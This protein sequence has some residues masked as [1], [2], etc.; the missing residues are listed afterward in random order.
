M[1]GTKYDRFY[2]DEL[3]K[4]YPKQEQLDVLFNKIKAITAKDVPAFQNEFLLI[5]DAK[6]AEIQQEEKNKAAAK[7]LEEESKAKDVKG[8]WNDEELELFRKGVIKFPTGTKN[9]WQV[10]SDYIGTRNT[11]QTIAKAKEI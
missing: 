9:R 6:Y 3:V 7:K 10:I 11:K 2:I 4:K 1:T 5:V 8:D